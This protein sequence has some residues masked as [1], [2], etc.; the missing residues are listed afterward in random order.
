[1]EHTLD[2]LADQV[3]AWC[4]EHRVRPA[5]GQ[6]STELTVRTLRY[7][8]TVNLLDAP[9]SGGGQGYG[10]R[11]F[12]QACVVRVLQ[13]Q[14]LPLSRIQSLTFGRSD[15]E[16]QAI[17]DAAKGGT[18]QLPEDLR[19]PM[20]PETWH[21]WPVTPDFMLISRRPG[22]HLTPAQLEAIQ[23]ILRK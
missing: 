17:L 23:Q 18:D 5:N 13:A 2:T 21:T 16:L 11:H 10:A 3:N 20:T 4:D 14:G 12:L 15:A 22:L 6:A 1:M 19:I 8:R 7:Y 9:T